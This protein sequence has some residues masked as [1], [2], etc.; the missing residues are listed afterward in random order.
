MVGKIGNRTVS[1][2]IESG[3]SN[4][5]VAPSVVLNS[6]LK[7]SNLKVAE[8]VWLATETKR[9]VIEIMRRFPLEINDLKT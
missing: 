9:K 7:K 4:S 5:Y 1:I 2:L 6:S 8:I 3:A